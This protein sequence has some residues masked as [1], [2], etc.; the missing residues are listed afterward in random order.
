LAER[1]PFGADGG[2]RP[3][4]TILRNPSGNPVVKTGE[5]NADGPFAIDFSNASQA[6]GWIGPVHSLI[7]SGGSR[8]QDTIESFDIVD[9]TADSTLQVSAMPSCWRWTTQWRGS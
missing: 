9:V 3:T 7:R 6:N 2:R 4:R 5:F 1:P 8:N